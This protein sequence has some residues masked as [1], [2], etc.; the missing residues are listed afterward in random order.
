MD[1]F[2]R[3]ANVILAIPEEQKDEYVSRGFD[4]VTESGVVVEAAIP[5]DVPTLQ[6][7][8]KELRD[9]NANLRNKIVELTSKTPKRKDTSANKKKAN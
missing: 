2:V 5:H 3:Q 8:L 9:E 6:S 1:I 4:V 7:K